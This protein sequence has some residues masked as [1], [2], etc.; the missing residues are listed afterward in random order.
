MGEGWLEKPSSS[1]SG[2]LKGFLDETLGAYNS[3][4]DSRYIQNIAQ[5]MSRWPLFGVF[6]WPGYYNSHL[7]QAHGVE[8][9][10]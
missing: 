5:F 9:D 2:C 7:G 1:G 6:E 8:Y 10:H 3:Y 4:I